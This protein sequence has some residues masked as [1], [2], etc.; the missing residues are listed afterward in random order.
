MWMKL[1]VHIEKES[2]MK[3]RIYNEEEK[4]KNFHKYLNLLA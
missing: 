4:N 1:F 2:K 3:I